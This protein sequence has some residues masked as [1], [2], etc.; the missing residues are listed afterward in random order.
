[1]SS[2][3]ALRLDLHVHTIYSG[4]SIIRP[5]EALARAKLVGLH[6]LAIT[7]HETLAGGL[8]AV[9]LAKRFGLL[10]LPGM[11][12]ET[13]GGHILALCPTEPI[14]PARELGEVLDAIRDAD[15]LA[16]LAHP[17]DL[18]A[19]KRWRPGELARLDAIEVL[20]AHNIPFRLSCWLAEKMARALGKPMTG[21]SD[22]HVPEAIGAAYT[23]VEAE[24]CVEDVLMAI[25]KGRVRPAGGSSGIRCL[26]KKWAYAGF[27]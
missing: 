16:I 3:G 11:E 27:R 19:P 5:E 6:G 9:K 22:A 8:R 7:D 24:P 21:G 15:G 12:I 2:R 18:T 1:M 20:N 17:Y 25:R 13:R 23:I 10:V 4:D 14:E 26:L